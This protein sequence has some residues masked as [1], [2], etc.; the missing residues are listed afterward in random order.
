MNKSISICYSRYDT[1]WNLHIYSIINLEKLS[2]TISVMSNLIKAPFLEVK[3]TFY[4]NDKIVIELFF[5]LFRCI[6]DWHYE[7]W[8][9]IRK[10]LVEALYLSKSFQSQ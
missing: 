7:V 2:K 3:W 10:L 6:Q 4:S 9:P 8:G 5:F 1:K